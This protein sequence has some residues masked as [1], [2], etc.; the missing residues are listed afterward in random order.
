MTFLDLVICLCF[1]FL[2]SRAAFAFFDIASRYSDAFAIFA[3]LV[4]AAWLTV[5]VIRRWA[6][7]PWRDR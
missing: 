1:G 4:A 2:L 7:M 3:A 6:S 5:I